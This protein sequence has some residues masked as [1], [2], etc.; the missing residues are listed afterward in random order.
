MKKLISELCEIL[1]VSDLSVDL[2]FN[3]LLCY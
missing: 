2:P 3:K 1:E